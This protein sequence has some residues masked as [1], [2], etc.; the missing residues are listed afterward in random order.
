[1][2]WLVKSVKEAIRRGDWNAVVLFGAQLYGKTR[3]VDP[4]LAET[5]RDAVAMALLLLEH[6]VFECVSFMLSRVVIERLG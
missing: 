1:M 5:A 4:V 3:T 2:Q 6:P